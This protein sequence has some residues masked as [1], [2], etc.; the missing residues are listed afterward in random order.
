MSS[1]NVWLFLL[2][3]IISVNVLFAQFEDSFN[4]GIICLNYS[5]C[6]DIYYTIEEQLDDN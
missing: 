5:S 3:N 6:K 1:K 2:I 4:D